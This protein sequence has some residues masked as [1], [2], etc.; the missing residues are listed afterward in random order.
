MTTKQQRQCTEIEA[1]TEDVAAVAAA[2]VAAPAPP[3]LP[4]SEAEDFKKKFPID[5]VDPVDL[6][7]FLKTHAHSIFK[8]LDVPTMRIIHDRTM[9]DI[10]FRNLVIE[11]LEKEEKI[12]VTKRA[13][14]AIGNSFIFDEIKKNFN[15][16]TNFDL[17]DID[18]EGCPVL[19]REIAT[20]IATR[21]AASISTL[22][23]NAALK[24]F[25]K[26]VFVLIEKGIVTNDVFMSFNTPDG[27]E[28]R[29]TTY[30]MLQYAIESCP[31]KSKKGMIGLLQYIKAVTIAKGD[32]CPIRCRNDTA[33]T[34]VRNIVGD[35][36]EYINLYITV[37]ESAIAET[38]NEGIIHSSPAPKKKRKDIKKDATATVSKDSD[39]GVVKTSADN[40]KD[41]EAT[42]AAVAAA[43]A[44]AVADGEIVAPLKSNKKPRKSSPASKKGG[45]S[46]PDEGD[47]DDAAAVDADADAADAAASTKSPPPRKK[48]AAAP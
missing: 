4:L 5:E 19:Q 41:T 20:Y 9:L 12:G 48:R 6:P 39:S 46:P 23:G 2:A 14:V 47:D 26:S 16:K 40:S 1:D 25:V 28:H 42:T 31:V 15:A 18:P 24:S 10:S 38:E 11:Y 21:L 29:E 34:R 44:V 35:F 43:A 7:D 32:M 8:Y 3:A 36:D 45:A 22:Y 33:L 13:T 27:G 17:S 30:I 37:T